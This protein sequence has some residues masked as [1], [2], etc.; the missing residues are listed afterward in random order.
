MKINNNNEIASA[1]VQME[2]AKKVRMKILVGLKDESDNIFMRHFTVSPGGN[3]PY[4]QHNYEHV[5]KIEKNRGIAVDENGNE[6]EVREGQSLFVRPNEL[7]QFRNPFSEEF[8][9]LCIIPNPEKIK[10]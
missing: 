4:H 1:E 5:I 10:S 9:F 7:H 6:H 3:T 8:E 2:G